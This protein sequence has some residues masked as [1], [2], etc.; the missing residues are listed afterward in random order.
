PRHPCSTRRRRPTATR[1]ASASSPG[2]HRPVPSV[3]APEGVPA[4]AAPP[5]SRPRFARVAL[6]V[7]VLAVAALALGIWLAAGASRLPDAVDMGSDAKAMA[8][9]P[10]AAMA[11]RAPTPLAA[12]DRPPA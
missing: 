10:G 1:G 6:A 3:V 2:D 4:M 5:A 7:V 11:R 8:M 12:P 9:A